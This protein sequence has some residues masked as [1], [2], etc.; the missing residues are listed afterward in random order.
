M[1]LTIEREIRDMEKIFALAY[2][3]TVSVIN[4]SCRRFSYDFE[5]FSF[6]CYYNN[7]LT[8]HSYHK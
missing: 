4:A 7:V 2:M 6:V 8:Y 1:I 5:V 3:F